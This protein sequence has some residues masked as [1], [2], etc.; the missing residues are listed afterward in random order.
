LTP[1]LSVLLP[2]R[3]A[4]RFLPDCIESIANQSFSHFE[5]IAIDDGSNDETADVLAAWA[6][7][8]PRV[9][10]LQPGPIGLIKA[11]TIASETAQ[12]PLLARM[13][14]DDIALPTR[15]ERQIEWLHQQDLAACGTQVRYFPEED[16]REGALAYQSWLNSLRTRQDIA[17]D[18]FVEC[19]IAHPAL[20]IRHA[21]FDRVGGYRD[22]DWPEDYDLV[23][24]L[25]AGG[26]TIGNVPEMLLNWRERS[27]RLSRVDV[28][29]STDAFTR[30]KAHYL[31]R[32]LLVGRPAIVWGAG[33]V[34]KAMVRAL[35]NEGVATSAFIDID[36][37]KIGQRP[38]GIPVRSP[39]TLSQ[40]TNAFVLAAVG[41]VDARAQI[42]NSLA[43]LGLIEMK[44]YCAVA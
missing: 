6:K 32:T 29:Y 34:G 16:V 17:R 42:R 4:A 40:R 35:E 9:V 39:D 1:A 3:N 38:Y 8:D 18:I 44:D 21:A 15:F 43:N 20:L 25:W 2:C 36:P 24:R 27:D 14:A 22:T 5:V 23:L 7:R 33:P 28:R 37:K 12:A 26:H 11:L 19:P 41:S 10:V 13:D 31:A 30:C